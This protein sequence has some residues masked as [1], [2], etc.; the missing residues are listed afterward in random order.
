MSNLEVVPVT[1]E[2]TDSDGDLIFKVNAFD[3]ATATVE[4][5]APVNN[6]SWAVI[7]ASIA[8]CLQQMKLRGEG[9]TT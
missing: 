6:K 3:D 8:D 2:A 1:F 9:E 4:I 7:A 5:K